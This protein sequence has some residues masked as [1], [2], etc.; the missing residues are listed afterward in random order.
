[1]S[2]INYFKVFFNM[3]DYVAADARWVLM[4]YVLVADV[5]YLHM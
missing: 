4:W 3:H 5:S 1:M 2:E